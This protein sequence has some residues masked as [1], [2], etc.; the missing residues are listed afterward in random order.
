MV[1]NDLLATHRLAV[2]QVEFAR[3]DSER[4]DKL[5]PSVRRWSGA[6]TRSGTMSARHGRSSYQPGWDR[7]RDPMVLLKTPTSL[8]HIAGQI[9][10]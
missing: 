9:A 2:E 1:L 6:R 8:E 4:L 10:E 5:N 3:S 7:R